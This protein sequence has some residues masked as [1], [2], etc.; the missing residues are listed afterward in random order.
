MKA[1]HTNHGVI[2]DYLNLEMHDS[3][4]PASLMAMG[5]AELET[6]YGTLVPQY[7]VEDM[8][9][10]EH[11][12]ILF[13]SNGAL[14]KV[15]LQE[16]QDIKTRYGTMASELLL[17]YK[18]GA[19]KR[20]FPLSGKLSGFWTEEHEYAL[21]EDLTLSLPCGEIT[22]K[23][24]CLGFFKSGA[25]RSV[26]LWPG[27][28]AAVNTVAGPIA[29]RTGISFY[30]TG[31]VRSLE[32]RDPIAIKTPIGIVEAFDNDPDGI[33]GDM[34]SLC[35]DPAGNVSALCTTSSQVIV[36]VDGETKKTYAP[37]EKES[38]CSETIK[39]SVPLQIEFF[40]EKVRFNKNPRDEYDLSA[41]SFEIQAYAADTRI[42]CYECS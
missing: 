15:P 28:T 22:A 27:E 30:D 38:L 37:E 24:I 1:V 33:S 32:P 26:T 8:G 35:F 31:A 21:A 5:P 12:Y 3:G 29:T 14:R 9:R 23:M 42:P 4:H 25:I 19:L 6:A 7:Q 2:S 34:N 13:H 40:G 18:D 20:L 39:I 36:T 10:K 16:K 41:C 17:F 11:K